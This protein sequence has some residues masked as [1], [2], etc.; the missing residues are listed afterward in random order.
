MQTCWI[1]LVS[2]GDGQAPSL[3][4][5]DPP[6][7]ELLPPAA[8]ADDT[9]EGVMAR[10]LPEARLHRPKLQAG[11]ALLFGGGTVQRTHADEA[12]PHDRISLELR[13]L[14]AGAWPARLGAP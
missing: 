4:C 8:L 1:P 13:W 12:M 5:F 10:L 14:P 2:C 7:P 9:F 3:A 6:W 11:D